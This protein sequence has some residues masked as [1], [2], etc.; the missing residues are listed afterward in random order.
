[1]HNTILIPYGIELTRHELIRDK[2]VQ[3]IVKQKLWKSIMALLWLSGSEIPLNSLV[4]TSYVE[5][6]PCFWLMEAALTTPSICK[7][8]A[9][10]ISN[11]KPIPPC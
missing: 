11:Q 8:S 6:E 3:D 7:L 5:R 10:S 4:Y 2:L 1:M 9:S